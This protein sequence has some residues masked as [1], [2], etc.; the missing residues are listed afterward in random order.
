MRPAQARTEAM[1]PL[2][3]MRAGTGGWGQAWILTIFLLLP[4]AAGDGTS[5]ANRTCIRNGLSG[6]MARVE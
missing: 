4:M 1:G 2:P 6:F 3:P 5:L